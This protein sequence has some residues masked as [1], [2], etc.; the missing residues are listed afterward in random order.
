MG[1]VVPQVANVFVGTKKALPFLT[2]RHA[3]TSDFVRSYGWW[4]L[5]A[6]ILIALGVHFAL[7]NPVYREKV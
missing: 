7:K 4:V 3:G 6:F 1:Y 2:G 5:A